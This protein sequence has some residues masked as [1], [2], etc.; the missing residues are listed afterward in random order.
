MKTFSNDEDT[1]KFKTQ[2]RVPVNWP[3]L[4]G[5]YRL[6]ENGLKWK[7]GDTG[8]KEKIITISK[9]MLTI[10]N[11]SNIYRIYKFPTDTTQIIKR[12]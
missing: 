12:R 1:T 7:H 6:K 5:F 3:T 11:K 2:Q 10:Q 8:R 4:K 9:L